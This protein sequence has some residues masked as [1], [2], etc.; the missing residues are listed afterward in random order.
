[1]PTM[2]SS[3]LNK[4]ELRIHIERSA[5]MFN[6]PSDPWYNYLQPFRIALLKQIIKVQQQNDEKQQNE[7]Q[8]E[9]KQSQENTIKHS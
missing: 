6:I 5:H 9:Q 4:I 8:H 7:Q 2:Q 3:H 1:M